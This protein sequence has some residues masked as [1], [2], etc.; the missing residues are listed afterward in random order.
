[1]ITGRNRI[2]T[3]LTDFG[4]QD[5]YVGMMKGAIAQINPRLTVIDLTHQIPPQD[6]G[7][8]RFALMSA[9]PYFPAETVHVTVVDPGVGSR[10]RAIAIAVGRDATH[11]T[12]FL[13]GPDNGVLSGVLQQNPVLAAVELTN[14]VYWRTPSPSST[15]HGRDIFAPVAAHLASGVPLVE[16]GAVISTD[17]LQQLA[18]PTCSYKQDLS[19][20]ATTITGCIQ[21]I[22]RFGN[23]ITNIPGTDVLGKEWLAIVNGIALCGKQ[24]YSERQAGELLALVGSHGWVEIAVNQGSAQATL[25]L[26]IGNSVQVLVKKQL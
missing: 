23:L 16:L 5:P 1:M 14:S 9:Y 13:I 17:T 4:L 11:P 20:P 3:L 22:D 10:R 25:K 7:S 19:R 21:A 15:F 8:A 18:I 24:T 26:T 2:L 12:G 6:I